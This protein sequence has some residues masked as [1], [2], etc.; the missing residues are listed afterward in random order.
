MEIMVNIA[1]NWLAVGLFMLSALG[2]AEALVFGTYEPGRHDRFASGFPGTSATASTSS[3]FL[4]NDYDLSGIGWS[5]DDSRHTVTMISPRH[6][7]TAGNVGIP[8]GG[9]IRFLDIGGTTHDYVIESLESAVNDS[10][11]PTD[12]LV[13]T[14]TKDVASTITFYPIA[15]FNDESDYYDQSLLI[16]GLGSRWGTGTIVANPNS[17]NDPFRTSAVGGEGPINATRL[18]NFNVDT[19]DSSRSLDDVYFEVGDSSGPTFIVFDGTLAL[20]GVH[21]AVD[22][23]TSLKSSVDTFV[24]HYLD[25]ID[26]FIAPEDYSATRIG[27][28]S[29]EIPQ[30]NNPPS[31][32]SSSV[33]TVTLTCTDSVDPAQS[34]TPYFYKF[35]ATN[36]TSSVVYNVSVV[37][38]LPSGVTYKGFSDSDVAPNADWSHD[39]DVSKG[40]V[41]VSRAQIS[42]DSSHTFQI[43]VTPPAKSTEELVLSATID[44]RENANALTVSETTQVFQTFSNFVS[45]LSDTTEGGDPDN[46]GIPSLLEYFLDLDPKTFSKTPDLLP[47]SDGTLTFTRRRRAGVSG[48]F[49]VSND[50]A[51]WSPLAGTETSTEIDYNFE[52]VTFTPEAPFERGDRRFL[53]F[54]VEN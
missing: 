47:A 50:L 14:L 33:Q 37:I 18:F 7:I 12:L 46:D 31:N 34:D 48:T 22:G 20:V 30:I 17:S 51:G 29:P 19:T 2:S 43:T 21:A 5:I 13:G 36:H 45:D 10:N 28:S 25:Q 3:T 40:E 15:D 26:E 6:F 27:G 49:M 9:T 35:T 42:R 54:K 1:P 44:Y 52:K 38:T 24:P 39:V 53:K 8:G 16:Q 4:M 32:I 11:E 41:S 23:S